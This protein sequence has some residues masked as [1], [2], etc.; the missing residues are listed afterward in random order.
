MAVTGM[1]NIRECCMFPR[2]RDRLVP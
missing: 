1:Q 2:D